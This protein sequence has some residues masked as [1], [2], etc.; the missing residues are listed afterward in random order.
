VTMVV[1]TRITPRMV[2]LSPMIVA[3]PNFVEPRPRLYAWQARS[4][5]A[6]NVGVS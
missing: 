2:Q 6:R 3:L 5:H 1:A 4:Q